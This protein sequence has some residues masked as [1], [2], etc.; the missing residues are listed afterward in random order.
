M[1][2]WPAYQH[3]Y[4]RNVHWYNGVRMH[5]GH[6]DGCERVFLARGGDVQGFLRP[7][8][9]PTFLVARAKSV[10]ARNFGGEAATHSAVKEEEKERKR[11]R[12]RESWTLRRGFAIRRGW[13][14]RTTRDL[15]RE[16]TIYK[17]FR[18]ENEEE[19]DEEQCGTVSYTSTFRISVAELLPMVVRRVAD[20][21]SSS[22]FSAVIPCL[23]LIVSVY[24][25]TER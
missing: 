13:A 25:N 6:A 18:C 8:N 22:T 7:E 24:S 12:E 17:R 1:C 11:E 23:G 3:T 15:K 16:R 14:S 4:T 10:Q 21:S 19:G 9:L 2:I 5:K 20:Y